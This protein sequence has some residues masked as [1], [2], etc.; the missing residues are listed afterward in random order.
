MNITNVTV[1]LDA[2]VANFYL[3]ASEQDQMRMQWLLNLWLK[4]ELMQTP[5]RSLR[6]VMD[7]AGRIA[8]EN[9]MTEEVLEEI[10]RQKP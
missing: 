1:P 7:E 4:K 8:A 3:N 10:L 2:D 6:D 5:K 9:G